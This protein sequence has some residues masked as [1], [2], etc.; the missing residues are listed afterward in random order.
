MILLEIELSHCSDAAATAAAKNAK[1]F[2]WPGQPQKLLLPLEDLHPH[3]IHGSV[4]PPEC[5]CKMAC[6]SVQPLLHSTL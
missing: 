2:E 5:S 1:V 3:P 4:D 6:Q